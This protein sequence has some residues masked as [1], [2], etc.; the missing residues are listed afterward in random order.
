MKRLIL[1]SVV[2]FVFTLTSNKVS[3]QTQ[4]KT[5]KATVKTEQTTT[6]QDNFVDK[7]KNGVCDNHEAKTDKK[8][9]CKNT[10]CTCNHH[11]KKG[12]GH[13]NCNGKG[14][15]NA[16]GSCCGNHNGNGNH[17][18]NGDGCQHSKTIKTEEVPKK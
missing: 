16:K 3:A 17:K 12:N 5:E 1:L 2:L 18:S 10:N 14:H 7:D 11:G 9:N 13:S 8:A 4:E 6:T 15:D